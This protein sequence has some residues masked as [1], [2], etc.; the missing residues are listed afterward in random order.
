MRWARTPGRAPARAAAPPARACRIRTTSRPSRP[1]P[2]MDFAPG[3][4][5]QAV[6]SAVEAI[7]AR[8]GDDYWLRRDRDG[9]FPE[10]FHRA[11]AEGGWLGIAM[12]REYGGAGLG[13]AE[14]ATMM[15]AVSASGAGMSGAS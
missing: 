3:P 6:R 14:A 9:G 4:D 12:P 5:Q 2:E 10:D 15:E 13:I 8:F 1:T 11:I 7:C